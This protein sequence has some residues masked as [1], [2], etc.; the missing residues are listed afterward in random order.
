MTTR[1]MSGETTSKI[2]GNMAFAA[3]VDMDKVHG[4][5]AEFDNTAKH[6]NQVENQ[7]NNL[8]AD[9][10]RMTHDVE[11]KVENKYGYMHQWYTNNQMTLVH[12]SEQF[13]RFVILLAKNPIFRFLNR[14]FLHWFLFNIYHYNYGTDY[15][16][17]SYYVHITIANSA[18][19]CGDGLTTTMEQEE[20]K[21]KEAFRINQLD[22]KRKL[23][24]IKSEGYTLK[25]MRFR[26]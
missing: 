21:A 10:L 23:A 16:H 5:K 26:F 24:E 9:T 22:F 3:G 14:H 12:T 6:I 17:D 7:L 20:Q 4:L 11:M 18:N 1:F 13:R 8:R 19:W 15:Y 2:L 25:N